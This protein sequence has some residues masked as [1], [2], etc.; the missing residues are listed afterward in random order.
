MK[1]NIEKRLRI[2]IIEPYFGG[3]HQAFLEGLLKHIKADCTL[4]TL[5]ARSWKSRMQLSAPWFASQFAK[6]A[7]SERWFDTVLCSTFVDVAVLRALLQQLEGWN[8]KTRYCT[9]FHENQFVYPGQFVSTGDRQF[10]AINFTTAVV[11]DRLAFNSSFNRQTFFTSCGHYLK[12]TAGINLTEVLEKIHARS[13]V[14]H[15]GIDYSRID[16]ARAVKKSN[17]PV[18]IWNHRWE[19][20]K[21]PE[22]FFAVLR[23]LKNK[24]I[25]FQMIVLGQSFKTHP[26]CFAEAREYFDDRI[27]HFG[28]VHREEEYS[29]L[30]RTG[31]IVVST[32]LHEFFGISVLEAV[33]A[34]CRPLLP[35]RLSYPELFPEEFLYGEG[36]LEKRLRDTLCNFK[37]LSSELSIKYTEPYSWSSLGRQYQTWLAA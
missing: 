17:G 14:L 26:E 12:K 13:C 18:I 34:G 15:P 32:A 11:S 19:H 25:P 4:L 10:Q 5:P 9:Y 2:L 22:E 6:R 29:A 1:Q 23:F 8:P 33:R 3:S 16:T 31:D 20:D 36:E 7:V 30:L 35:R 21:N 27:I 24:G 28:Y 37:P